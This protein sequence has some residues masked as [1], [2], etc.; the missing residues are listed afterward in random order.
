MAIHI[1]LF[2]VLYLSFRAHKRNSH[3]KYGW[4]KFTDNV[5]KAISGDCDK[6]VFLLVGGVAHKKEKMIDTNKHAVVKTAHPSPRS[7]RLF[8]GCNCFSDCNEKLKEFG[9]PPIDWSL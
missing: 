8:K 1:N 2:S 3:S 7:Y 6:V 4:Q 5:I 9:L